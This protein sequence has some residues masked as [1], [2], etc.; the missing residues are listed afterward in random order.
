MKQKKSKTL[1]LMIACL[2]AIACNNGKQTTSTDTEEQ[3]ENAQKTK[4]YSQLLELADN[5]LESGDLS[6]AKAYYWMGYASDR[7][8]K[9]RMAEFYWKASL[10]AA[11][12]T[13]D[14]EDMDIYAK[15]A[16]RLANLLMVR[17]DYEGALKGAIP[18]ATRLEEEKCDSTSDY[19]NLLIYIG[20]CQEG[21]G[22]TSEST[23]EGFE[24][25]YKKH[26]D[27]IEKTHSDE[28]YKDAIAGLINIAY[29]CN[30][31]KDYT[32]SQK[33]IERFGELLKDYEQRPDAN[34]NYVDKQVARF[35]IYKA[36]ALEGL[37]QRE[38]AANVYEE[39]KTKA[40]SQTPEGHIIANYYLRAA[41]RWA[42]AADNYKS[43]DAVLEDK[44][45][46]SLEDVDELLLKKY[47][48]NMISGRKDS[49]VAVSMQICDALEQAF[50]Q[51]QQNDKEEQAAIVTN[52]EKM[53]E[54]QAEA[55]K[56]SRMWWNIVL[57][58]LFLCFVVYVF[59]RHKASRELKE[60]YYDLQVAYDRLEDETISRER[61]A[62]EQR[63]A[64][65]IKN[66][67]EEPVL[68]RRRDLAS[69]FAVLPGKIE[70]GNF[71]DSFVHDGHL[72][73][74][75]GDTE[76]EGAE[77]SMLAT[78]TKA[79]FRTASAFEYE[80]KHILTTILEAGGATE[81]QSM[82]LFIG[83]LDLGNGHFTYANANQNAPVVMDG[84]L[85]KLDLMKQEEYLQ[86]GTLL[87]FYNDRLI[88]VENK[89]HKKYGEKRLLGTALQAMKM[90][91]R[92]KPF[93]DSIVESVN[94]YTNGKQQLSDI[95][96]CAIKYAP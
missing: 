87:F 56:K 31:I 10:E 60:A 63:I 80:P 52:V 85:K 58:A 24:R 51:A 49:A 54:Q 35:Y 90:D 81:E 3:I 22:N 4:N 46:I 25:A 53:T 45:A 44:N 94:T 74:C 82:K 2:L 72:F 73:I 88:Q 38:E 55:Q 61:L 16:S 34:P 43:L 64:Q 20:C 8:K 95:A 83:V 76:G 37:E 32:N 40:C 93:V 69:S 12:Q 66:A 78:M 26:L 62:T 70:G 6:P 96:M 71:C 36:V 48:A 23:N 79:Q 9:K 1:I 68:P 91:P 59:Y 18:A 21:L 84:E 86:P 50:E 57:V 89:E 92:P 65:T 67:I 7:M 39:F 75:V 13:T 41:E 19:L 14:A 47:Q 17:G 28:A 11:S 33:W 30:T 15:S 77:A 27:N 29:A 5:F 42:E